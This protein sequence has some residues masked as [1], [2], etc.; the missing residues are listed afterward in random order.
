MEDSTNITKMAI[1]S[2]LIYRVHAISVKTPAD[3]FAQTDKLIPEFIWNFKGSRI[4][5]MILK[6]ENKVGGFTFPNF[7][8]HCRA[9]LSK[10]IWYQRRASH[11][12]QWNRTESP[13]LNPH[14]CGQPIFNK[15]AKT[16]QWRKNSIF[17]KKSKE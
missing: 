1:L 13:E 3:F 10:T 11:L 12:D 5:R 7:K 15:A 17:S 9:A 2:K 6:K 4:A 16:I 14:L 8:T